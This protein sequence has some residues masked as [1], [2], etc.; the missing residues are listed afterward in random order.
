MKKLFAAAVI[1]GGLLAPTTVAL[2]ALADTPSCVSYGEFFEQARSG[3]SKKQITRKFDTR[4][5]E[6]DRWRSGRR[7][8]MLDTIQSYRACG[9]YRAD[10]V[11]LGFDDYTY[12]SKSR[13]GTL[14]AYAG[15]WNHQCLDYEDVYGLM[16]D[17]VYDP[18]TG[19]EVWDPEAYDGYL[20][21]Y[22]Y[23][24]HFEGEFYD[25]SLARTTAR[26]AGKVDRQ[27]VIVKRFGEVEQPT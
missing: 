7:G 24:R 16:G 14:R 11:V 23:D 6:L 5:R 25:E 13:G 1:A 15:T 19:E 9:A 21:S 3:D 20:Y 17:W 22:C 10:E 4:G 27:P 26:T 2:P 12:G 8:R 18:V